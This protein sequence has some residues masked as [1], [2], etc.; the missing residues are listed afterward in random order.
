MSK[1]P[2]Y[3]PEAFGLELVAEE[4]WGGSYEFDIRVVWLHKKSG[5]LYTAR[6]SGC[7]CPSPFENYT[8]LADLERMN[9]GLVE[10]V[11]AEFG[12]NSPEWE[13]LDKAWRKACRRSR[14]V[15]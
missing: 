7:S 1:N 13:A 3:N 10:S 4:D 14:K 9:E 12:V 2:Y 11:K 6:D 15:K 5:E 8:S